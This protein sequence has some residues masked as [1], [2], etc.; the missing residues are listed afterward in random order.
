MGEEGIKISEKITDV[1]YGWSP[2]LYLCFT[3]FQMSQYGRP[4]KG[5]YFMAS[6][7]AHPT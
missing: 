3:L 6:S 7:Q 4:S 2:R 5:A 1:F